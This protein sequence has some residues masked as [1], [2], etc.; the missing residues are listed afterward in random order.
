MAIALAI[1][2]TALLALVI[3][4]PLVMLIAGGWAAPRAN[5]RSLP[6][7]RRERTL[8]RAVAR[9]RRNPSA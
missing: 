6:F 3:A 8:Q 5:P 9:R 7:S 1:S 2:L 4:S